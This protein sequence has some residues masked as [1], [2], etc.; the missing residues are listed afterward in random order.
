MLLAKLPLTAAK[1]TAAIF[2]TDFVVMLAMNTLQLKTCLLPILYG[3]CLLVA[4]CSIFRAQIILDAHQS[5]LSTNELKWLVS[6]VFVLA[7]LCAGVR[8]PYLLEGRLHHLV[9]PLASDDNWHIQEINSLVNSL[10]YPARFSL[11]PTQYFSLYYAPWMMIAALYLAVPIHG[12]TIKA[13]F[14]I[15]CAIYQILFSLTFLHIGISIAQSRRHLYWAIY[16]VGFWAGIASL[17]ALLHPL[18]DSTWWMVS[19]G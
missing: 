1:L 12:F 18:Q 11:A 9:G 19:F 16:L 13:A 3:G 6:M 10:R 17:F 8:F 5:Y 15:G 14:A 4:G 7:L 2:C